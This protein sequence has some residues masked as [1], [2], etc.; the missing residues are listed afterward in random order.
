MDSITLARSGAQR[1]VTGPYEPPRVRLVTGVGALKTQ[2]EYRAGERAGETWRTARRR[3]KRLRHK[4]LPKAPKGAVES[5]LA[6]SLRHLRELGEREPRAWK[7][8]VLLRQ[9]EAKLLEGFP[10]DAPWAVTQGERHHWCAL[11]V[12]RT[13]SRRCGQAR[14]AAASA[15][16]L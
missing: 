9:Q 8:G 5:P 6:R 11:H 13:C 4:H 3:R 1:R 12:R 14:E 16:E 7:Q 15:A 10:K 2:T